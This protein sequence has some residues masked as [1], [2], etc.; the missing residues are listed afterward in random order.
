MVTYMAWPLA[1]YSE[2]A[3]RRA[4]KQVH[5]PRQLQHYVSI[6]CTDAW[7]LNVELSHVADHSHGDAS[8]SVDS[9]SVAQHQAEYKDEDCRNEHH[10]EANEL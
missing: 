10:C 4:V 7:R 5:T 8:D 6:V 3:K 9:F 2:M 1:L